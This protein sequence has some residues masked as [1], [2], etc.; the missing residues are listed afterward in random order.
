MSDD[1]HPLREW[2]FYISDMIDFAE[3][4]LTYT[5]GMD[6]FSFTESGINY[7]AVDL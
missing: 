2:F 5:E 1:A 7:D 4:V 3:K 6:Q